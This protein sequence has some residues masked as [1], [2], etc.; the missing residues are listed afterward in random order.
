MK[1]RFQIGDTSWVAELRY[2]F[3][4]TACTACKGKRH[5][6]VEGIDYVCNTCHGLNRLDTTEMQWTLKRVK[7]SSICLSGRKIMYS[8]S[9]G[10]YHVNESPKKRLFQSKEEGKAFINMKNKIKK[11]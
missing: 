6:T 7:I 11:S 10:D 5:V 9:E 3:S 1:Q 4:K 2:V 8:Y